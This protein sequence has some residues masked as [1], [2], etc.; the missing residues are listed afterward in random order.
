MYKYCRIEIEIHINYTS[1][2][3]QEDDLAKLIL[4]NLSVLTFFPTTKSLTVYIPY[5]NAQYKQLYLLKLQLFLSYPCQQSLTIYKFLL[6]YLLD[7]II[8]IWLVYQPIKFKIYF[9]FT[10][11]II[12]LYNFCIIQ[13]KFSRGCLSLIFFFYLLFQ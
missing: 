2:L 6:I 7:C 5:I 10:K 12:F 4:S 1:S 11:W 13:Q 9:K 8:I 3:S